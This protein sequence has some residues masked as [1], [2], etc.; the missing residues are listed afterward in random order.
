[1][2]L[3][4]K[5]LGVIILVVLFGGIFGSSVLNLWNTQSSK[6]PARISA[7][8]AAGEYNPE[9]IRGSH[10]FSEISE[11]YNI[12]LDVLA[13]GFGLPSDVDAATFANKDLES[14][15]G[16]LLEGDK[17]IGNGSVKLFV[18]LYTGLPYELPEDDYLPVP[19]VEILKKH[20]AL[21]EEEIAFLD[22]HTIDISEIESQGEEQE[23][24]D[25]E[26]SHDDEERII[27]GITTFADVLDWG[28]PEDTVV[29]I[30]SGDV[31]N[32]AMT[33]RDYCDQNNLEFSTVK[34]ELQAEVD[35]L[36][37]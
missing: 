24:T 22:A 37:P 35:K 18:A 19:A 2:I 4:S 20:A 25:T 13:N 23:Q 1:M 28:V 26:E 8:D 11:F 15:Y 30:I 29:S 10:Q 21:S 3:R 6:E 34:G 36:S 27:K 5:A 9:D 7:G 12:P 33:I 17:E 14:L 16:D 32:P 31:P